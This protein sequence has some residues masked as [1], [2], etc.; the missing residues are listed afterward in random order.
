MVID[1]T[2]S[3]CLLIAKS[4]DCFRTSQEKSFKKSE[5][6]LDESTKTKYYNENEK[7]ENLFDI[8]MKGVK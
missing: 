1:L 3:E 7:L 4:I 8:F 5:K 6:K 2:R